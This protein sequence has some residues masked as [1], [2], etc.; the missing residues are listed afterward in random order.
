MKLTTT[1]DANLRRAAKRRGF[2]LLKRR[3]LETF[4]LGTGYMIVSGS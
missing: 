2:I 4:D 1:N 3:G